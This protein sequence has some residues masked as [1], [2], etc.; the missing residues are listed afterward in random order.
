MG[1]AWKYVFLTSFS[2]GD[3]D[4]LG[5]GPQRASSFPLSQV[6]RAQQ[7]SGGSGPAAFLFL[8]WYLV[9]PRSE[10]ATANLSIR[11]GTS[12]GRPASCPDVRTGTH[13]HTHTQRQ[14]KGNGRAPRILL[15]WNDFFKGVV[16]F[17]IPKQPDLKFV[18]QNTLPSI[19]LSKVRRKMGKK[20]AF[21]WCPTNMLWNQCCSVDTMKATKASYIH[22]AIFF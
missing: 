12:Q 15:S 10:A 14:E 8:K 13:T 3:A 19:W 22:N 18:Q 2:L 5:Q 21:R 20:Y 11:E 16:P 4:L 1:R 6:L 9:L 17:F 7:Q